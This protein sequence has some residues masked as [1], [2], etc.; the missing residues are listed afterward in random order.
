M[1]ELSKG[2]GH[3]QWFFRKKNAQRSKNEECSEK[4][5]ILTIKN[6]KKKE[7]CAHFQNPK[8]E[9]NRLTSGGGW[10]RQ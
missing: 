6:P 5:Y 3:I 7:L 2:R 4:I 10:L 8:T 1:H 9:H